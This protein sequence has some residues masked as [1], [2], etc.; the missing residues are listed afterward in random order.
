MFSLTLAGITATATR[1]RSIMNA[2]TNNQ[3]QQ[4]SSHQRSSRRSSSR[5]IGVQSASVR[6]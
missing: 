6:D 1:I 4:Q 3:R 2:K 5:S